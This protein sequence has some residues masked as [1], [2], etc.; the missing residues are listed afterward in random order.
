MGA[1]ANPPRIS[2]LRKS[3]I[4]L[5]SRREDAVRCRHN[6]EQHLSKAGLDNRHRNHDE[7]SG[8]YGNTLVRTLRKIVCRRVSRNHATAAITRR[9][10]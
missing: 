8:K 5:W 10:I 3:L 6:V 4:A 2:W 9:I 1:V 7:I